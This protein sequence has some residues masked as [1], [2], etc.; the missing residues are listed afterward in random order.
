MLQKSTKVNIQGY[1]LDL[2]SYTVIGDQNGSNFHG[3]VGISG[4]QL[5]RGKK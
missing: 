3:V 4:S 1:P 2:S 5:M